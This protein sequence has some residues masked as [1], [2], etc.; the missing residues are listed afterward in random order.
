MSDS[1]NG[2]K[3]IRNLIASGMIVLFFVGIIIIYYFMLYSST[4]DNIMTNGRLNALSAFEKIERYLAVGVDDLNLTSHTIDNMLK[5]GAPNDYILKYLVEQQAAIEEILIDNTTGLYAYVDG[6]FMD[7][8]GWVPDDEF[9]ATERPWYKKAV[10]DPGKVVVV[11]PYMDANTHT[12]MITLA[13]C[14]CDKKSVVAMDLNMHELQ[15]IVENVTRENMCD[16][17]IVL[18]PTYQVVAHS[19]RDERGKVYREGDGTMGSALIG[20]LKSSDTDFFQMNYGGTVYMVYAMPLDNGWTCLSI[21]DTTNIYG[22]MRKPLVI[23]IVVAISVIVIIVIVLKHS[24]RQAVLAKELEIKSEKAIAASEAKSAFLSN[25]S[26]EIR[27]PINAVLGM[28]EMILRECRDEG[29][30]TY[31]ESIRAA[32]NT[33]L[34]LVNDILDFSKIEAGKIKIILVD[35]DL[36]SMI[37]D[38]VNMIQ[39]RAD[40]KGIELVLDFD[41]DIPKLLNG[42]EVRIKQIITNIL[43]NAVKY[44]EKGSITFKMGCGRLGTDSY[45]VMLDVS[46]K[47]TGIG[48]KDED[49]QNLFSEF[50]R[51]DEERNRNIEGTGLGM[52]ITKRLLNMMGSSLK[53]KSTYG[54]GSEFSFSLKQRVIKWEPLGDYES[55]YR[56]IIGKKNTY[57]EKFTAPDARVLVID[58]NPLNITVF[59]NLLKQT[60]VR[61]VSA[62][63]GD[64]GIALAMAE[65]YDMIFLD[66]MM[67]GKNGIET[68]KELRAVPDCINKDTPVICL[69]ANAISGAREQYLA[70]GFNEYL[71]KPID[72]NKLEDM[73]VRFIPDDKI[74]MRQPDTEPA[75]EDTSRLEEYL[76][77][78]NQID[79]SEGLKNNGSGE[80]YLGSLRVFYELIQ[81]VAAELDDLYDRGDLDGY[82]IKV[83]A[84]KSSARI[85]GATSLAEKAQKL[86]NAG[87]EGDR[88]YISNEHADFLKDH[89]AFSDLLK[90]LFEKEDSDRKQVADPQ[91]MSAAYEEIKE[92]AAGMDYDRIEAAFDELKDY[93]IPEDEAGL[94]NDL[95]VAALQLE[96]EKI[97]ALLTD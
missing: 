43:T 5:E 23:T 25:M 2:I 73:M 87:K 30:R 64:G 42:D 66:H 49:M 55:T 62:T 15:A 19:E 57:R 22:R 28:N 45:S 32:G 94:W 67:P 52:S 68:L 13:K 17:E 33:L 58:D 31:S 54:E 90:G 21:T 88:E 8:V 71:T 4:K 10:S 50:E 51:I 12:V 89:L 1:K 26:H 6:E 95:K 70:E 35:Y 84:L 92:A 61:V 65:K 79:F 18:D 60:M 63:D 96:Y 36:S 78:Q 39:T 14:L 93:T 34:G 81:P 59:A 76:K 7:S 20:A 74:R 41:R 85:I 69:T 72:S 86:E 91:I 83:H 44:T 53:V 16:I 56:A 27:T 37:N 97:I 46:V 80:D 38:L 77:D 47:D 3:M 82:T 75:V 40:E 29:I 11:D 48:I 9:V 24:H